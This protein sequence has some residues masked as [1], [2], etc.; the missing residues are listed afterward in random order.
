MA[1][2][3]AIKVDLQGTEAQQKKLAKLEAEVKKLTTRRTELNKALK[4]GT[5]SLDKYGK[6]I[7]EV[8]TK[9]KAHRRELLTTREQVLGMDSFTTKLGKSF[10]KLG[11]TISGAFVGLF[12]IQKVF[13]IGTAAA[14][15]IVEL[16]ALTAS[17]ERLGNVSE[18]TAEKTSA[19]I[20]AISSTFG[21]STDDILTAANAVSQQFGISIDQAV[22][23]IKI[24]F[25]AGSDASG[26][27]I[28]ILK[29]YPALL[30][31][32][33]LNADETFA[34]IN[35]Q[36]RQGIYSDKGVDAI[37]EAGLRLRELPKAT[38]E[39]LDGIGLSSAE[40]EKALASGSKNIFQVIQDVSKRL[41]ELPEQSSAVGTA[42]ADIFGG[43]GEDAGLRFLTTLDDIDLSFQNVVDNVDDYGQSQL[44]LVNAQEG[45]NEVI[46]EF[47]GESSTGWNSI[48]TTVIELATKYLKDVFGVISNIRDR[49][50]ELF[51][52][53][54]AFRQVVFGI[55]SAFSVLFSTVSIPLKTL[56]ST[57]QTIVETFSF[58]IDGEFG[59]AG[60]AFVSGF[61]RTG[62]IIVDESKKIVDTFVD[63]AKAASDARIKIQTAEEKAI[64]ESKKREAEENKKIIQAQALEAA[65][66]SAEAK[67]NEEKAKKARERAAKTEQRNLERKAKTEAREKERALSNEERFLDKIEKLRIQTNLNAIE[68]EKATIREIK[69]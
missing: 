48:K 27:F 57:I 59:K 6:E 63:N 68:D 4:N 17:V 24:G 65:K 32:V 28:S 26:E 23:K 12:A 43:P 31:E 46:N 1:K 5:I 18:E 60:D 2:T 41:G 50:V 44:D 33:G 62:K 40:I 14:E 8:N 61:E 3:I 21:A 67:K 22:E 39:A 55:K 51:N 29:E 64:I 54:E 25:A 13:E 36:V 53:S 69:N 58:L 9:L 20:L 19:S 16:D 52:N 11:T 30:K 49:F 66:K 37:K 42:I 7:S 45:F 10:K 56:V 38:K 34:L 35:Q 15:L 47:F